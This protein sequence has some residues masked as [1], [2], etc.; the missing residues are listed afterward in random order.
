LQT[1]IPGGIYS[2]LS[3]LNANW[4]QA[5]ILAIQLK[6]FHGDCKNFNGPEGGSEPAPGNSRFSGIT[7]ENLEFERFDYPVVLYLGDG[8][9][10]VQSADQRRRCRVR[11]L[12]LLLNY[13]STFHPFVFFLDCFAF[14]S[15]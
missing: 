5:E 11:P 7:P 2:A 8:L 12:V 3:N 10:G 6:K 14:G 9:I 4:F 1:V 13:S 15:Q